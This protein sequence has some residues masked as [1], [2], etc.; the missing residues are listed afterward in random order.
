VKRFYE[1]VDLLACIALGAVTL[2]VIAYLAH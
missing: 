2:A 1:V